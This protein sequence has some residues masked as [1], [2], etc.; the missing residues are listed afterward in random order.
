M[1][2]L[3]VGVVAGA[4]VEEGE[5]LGVVAVRVFYVFEEM[6]VFFGEV[7]ALGFDGVLM[8]GVE[9]HG[10]LDVEQPEGFHGG[11]AASGGAV[12]GLHLAVVA[13]EALFGFL[14]EEVGEVG[15]GVA[16]AEEGEPVVA[17]GAEGFIITFAEGG[18][19]LLDIV[20][21]DVREHACLVRVLGEGGLELLDLQEEEVV[22]SLVFGTP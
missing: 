10:D 17:V 19:E 5:E 11:E 15:G 8:P 1:G 4:E 12:D 21:L 2:E 20:G 14:G 3:A 18:S 16:F 6:E 7:E 22:G 13:E 9:L